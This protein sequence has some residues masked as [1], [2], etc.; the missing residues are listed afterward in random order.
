VPRLQKNKTSMNRKFGFK[1][2]KGRHTLIFQAQ[3]VKGDEQN[4]NACLSLHIKERHAFRNTR[5]ILL[6]KAGTSVI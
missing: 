3:L 5:L 1:F 6:I 2:I 4:C